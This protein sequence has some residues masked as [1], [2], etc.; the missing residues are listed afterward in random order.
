MAKSKS[1]TI[2]ASDAGGIMKR[3]QAVE[4][5]AQR[6]HEESQGRALVRALLDSDGLHAVISDQHG[7]TLEIAGGK[8]AVSVK[9]D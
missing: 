6:V 7:A 4:A 9:Q 3:F 5:E 8:V 1:L 2:A